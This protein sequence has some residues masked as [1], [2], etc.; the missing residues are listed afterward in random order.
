MKMRSNEDMTGGES[1]RRDEKEKRE[2]QKVEKE[3]A[4]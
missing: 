1:K 3:K 2:G 4:E